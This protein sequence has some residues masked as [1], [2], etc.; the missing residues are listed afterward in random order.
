MTD[1]VL[2]KGDLKWMMAPMRAKADGTERKAAFTAVIWDDV[3]YAKVATTCHQPD[4]TTVKR[5]QSGVLGRVDR[6]SLEN[7]SE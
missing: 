3:R 6:P 5:R 1:P 4:A 7:I 2:T